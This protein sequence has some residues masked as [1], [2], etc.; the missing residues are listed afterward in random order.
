MVAF[1]HLVPAL[2]LNVRQPWPN[3][4]QDI[5]LIAILAYSPEHRKTPNLN[6]CSTRR[7]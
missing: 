6:I 7:H 5:Q 2:I 3:L 4:I 1:N